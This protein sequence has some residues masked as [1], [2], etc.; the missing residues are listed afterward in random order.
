MITQEYL[1]ECLHYDPDTGVFT[2]LARP[3]T[4]FKRN[5][6]HHTCNTR[7]AGKH[8][9]TYTKA[10]RIIYRRITIDDALY[11]SH[12]LAWLYVFGEF[13]DGFIDHIDGD[14]SNNRLV[15]LRNVNHRENCKNRRMN[16]NNNTGLMCVSLYKGRGNCHAR[17]S[18][19]DGRKHLGYFSSLADAIEARK[20]AELEYGYHPNHGKGR[21]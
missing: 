4:H 20:A 7:L 19:P 13:P 17:I 8:A 14:G 16:S 11:M 12:R 9:G 10:G 1:K 6:V 3:E 18:T 2:W 21:T 5:H 15:N